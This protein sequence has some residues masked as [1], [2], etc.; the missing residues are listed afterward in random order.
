MVFIV[1][2]C[3]QMLIVI[4]SL[5]RAICVY[6][7]N[8]F[9][10]FFFFCFVLFTDFNW[11]RSECLMHCFPFSIMNE[12]WLP[13]MVTMEW[14]VC[15]IRYKKCFG[16]NFKINL[17]HFLCNF[18]IFYMMNVLFSPSV[19]TRYSA[20]INSFEIAVWCTNKSSNTIRPRCVC[21]VVLITLF[22]CTNHPKILPWRWFVDFLYIIPK[23]KPKIKSTTT[24][25]T[26]IS[27]DFLVSW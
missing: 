18:G 27:I 23:P 22:W 17:N 3:N 6:F 8:C 10:I 21:Y 24:T 13:F 11:I 25:T 2:L 5:Y 20:H 4:M 16:F 9:P 12:N 1:E 7:L 19:I 14:I 26:Y 15:K